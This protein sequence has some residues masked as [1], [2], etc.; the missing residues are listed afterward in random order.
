MPILLNA[1][2]VFTADKTVIAPQN[3]KFLCAY[4]VYAHK[5]VDRK[6]GKCYIIC[7]FR[8]AEFSALCAFGACGAVIFCA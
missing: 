1:T 4:T 5:N 2:P 6:G 8:M 7:A 3:E